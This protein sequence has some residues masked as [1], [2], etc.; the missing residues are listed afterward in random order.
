M[1][2]RVAESHAVRRIGTAVLHSWIPGPRALALLSLSAAVSHR[3]S[4]TARLISPNAKLVRL[5]DSLLPMESGVCERRDVDRVVKNRA[6]W[7]CGDATGVGCD[8]GAR[9][10]SG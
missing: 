10:V 3:V 5:V 6:S 2:T 9:R 4:A 8:R 7:G 1:P